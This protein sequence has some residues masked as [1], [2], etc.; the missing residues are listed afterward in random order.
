M[1][2]FSVNGHIYGINWI[3]RQSKGQI[4]TPALENNKNLNPIQ[5]L[6][7][8]W[9]LNHTPWGTVQKMLESPTGTITVV[10]LLASLTI[11][12]VIPQ[13]SLVRLFVSSPISTLKWLGIESF[14]GL[15]SN[16]IV[17]VVSS[18]LIRGVCIHWSKVRPEGFA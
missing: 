10:A 9:Q 1:A 3:L 15:F 6:Q 14:W 18:L 2:I 13:F 17:W 12:E 4:E 8:V 16:V 11:A 5:F 7:D